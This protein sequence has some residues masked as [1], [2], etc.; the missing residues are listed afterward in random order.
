MLSLRIFELH[1]KIVEHVLKYVTHCMLS[2]VLKY[3]LRIFELP[4][5]GNSKYSYEPLNVNIFHDLRVF[6]LNFL[7]DFDVSF[8]CDFLQAR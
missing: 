5:P 4:G 8:G 7:R 2:T 6:L 3:A 1:I